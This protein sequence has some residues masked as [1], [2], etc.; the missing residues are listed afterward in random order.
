M[1]FLFFRLLSRSMHMYMFLSFFFRSSLL[2]PETSSFSIDAIFLYRMPYMRWF[3]VCV[4]VCKIFSLKEKKKN[5]KKRSDRS[6][7]RI[8]GFKWAFFPSKNSCVE[9]LDSPYF[10]QIKRER[11]RTQPNARLNLKCN[12]ETQRPMESW[13]FFYSSWI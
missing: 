13:R 11:K 10:E 7:A 12:Y 4:S 8:F 1:R 3:H 5:R 6:V 2:L 9:M